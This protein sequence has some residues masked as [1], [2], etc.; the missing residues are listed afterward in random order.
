MTYLFLLC[1]I[2]KNAAFITTVY[3][4]NLLTPVLVL[5]GAYLWIPAGFLT[6]ALCGKTRKRLLAY[7]LITS[8]LMVV[9]IVYFRAFST[10][11]TFAS[12][13]SIRNLFNVSIIGY[14]FELIKPGDLLFFID[15]PLL[16]ILKHFKPVKFN[17]WL[18]RISAG[19]TAFALLCGS[20]LSNLNLQRAVYMGGFNGYVTALCFIDAGVMKLTDKQTEEIK[21]YLSLS[22]TFAV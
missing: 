6:F 22:N 7:D 15:I 11:P 20:Q 19:F 18:I 9:A 5:S 12:I 13:A 8:T 17:R 14:A 1:Q 3:N 10:L 2:L 16:I 4:E 21:T